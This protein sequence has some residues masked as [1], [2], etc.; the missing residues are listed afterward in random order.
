MNTSPPLWEVVDVTKAYAGVKV[1][2]GI[3]LQLH[4]GQI[5]A[6][7]GENG[8]GKSTLIKTLSGAH[9]P[10]S[11]RL[12]RHGEPV[13]LS[14]P[15]AAREFGVSTV[16]QEFSVVGALSVAENIYLGRPP[17]K[18][19]KLDWAAMR[20]SA[21]RVLE[22]MAVELDV[23]AEVASL[24]VAQQQ[25]VEIAKALAADASLI[26]L[27]EPTTALSVEEIDVLHRLLKRLKAERRA[28][29]YISHRLD[30][31]VELVDVA[32]ILKDGQ[33]VS[34]AAQSKIDIPYIV[35]CMV[36]DV[37]EHYPKE[38]NAR[39]EVL[40]EARS[41]STDN[42]VR[43]VSF[44][45]HRGEVLGLGGVLGSGRTEIARAIFGLDRLK[46]G[47]IVLRG[48]PLRLRHPRDAIAAGIA[49]VPEN[50]KS[51][52]LFFN[53][54]GFP[55]ISIANLRRLGR[56]GTL[57]PARE[58][59]QCRE[60]LRELELSPHAEH[61]TV[62]L[63]SGGNQ[64][65]VVIGRWL[66][67]DADVFILDEPTQGIDIGAKIAVYRLIN[68]LTAAGKGVILIS[69]DYDELVAMSDRVCTIRHGR[70]VAQRTPA[71][72]R[73]AGQRGVWGESEAGAA[74]VHSIELSIV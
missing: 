4:A 54:T 8:S 49:L 73:E 13:V 7:L 34:S 68:R 11:G 1:N 62:G 28:I 36:G 15:S 63:L 67:A 5:H 74:P 47:Q 48:E 26:I 16:F 58:R 2:D 64:Q 20:E 27:D 19:G 3:C 14:S 41:I 57:H 46:A 70:L 50:R 17:T 6:L 12:L 29:L 9:Q 56:Y 24:P 21:R 71:E 22:S 44:T 51:D 43:D 23:D 52:G 25:L 55:N 33:V 30:E 39:T 18:G 31:V 38:R 53:F 40:L 65:K 35:K 10:D 45:L 37:G 72:L 32:T 42:R 61:R 59:E 66:H 69:S 60:L